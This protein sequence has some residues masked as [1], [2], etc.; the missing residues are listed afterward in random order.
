M[1]GDLGAA[2]AALERCQR[3]HVEGPQLANEHLGPDRLPL[4]QKVGPAFRGFSRVPSSADR[5]LHILSWA[6]PSMATQ[7]RT[8]NGLGTAIQVVLLLLL[9]SILAGVLVVVLTAMQATQAPGQAVNGVTDQAT[10]ALG[11]AQQALRD[12]TDPNHPP[13]GLSYDTEFAALDTW[14]VG[15][16]LPGGTQYVLTVQSI[17]RRDNAESNDTAQY[18]VIHAELRQP[19]ESAGA[20]PTAPLRYRPARLHAVQGRDVPNRQHAVPRQ[21]DQ[22]A[23]R[24]AV[25][26]GVYR[27]PDAVRAPFKFA[28]D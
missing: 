18:A 22:P 25:A 15:Q 19:H 24:R 4:S 9:L 11:N 8:G 5:P 20:R 1:R 14:Q 21:L 23:S 10:R 13:S 7:Q 16:T 17:K 2:G 6:E 27:Q 26:A 12:A 3:H 28:Y